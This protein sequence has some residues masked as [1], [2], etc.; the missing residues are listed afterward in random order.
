MFC[1]LLVVW[2]RQP[3]AQRA[4][5]SL[6][7]AISLALACIPPLALIGVWGGL[8]AEGV[9]T[10]LSYQH[11]NATVGLNFVRPLTT[12]LVI[13]V[14]ALPALVF[15]GP[16]V[17]R[18]LP[19]FAVAAAVAS[20]IAHALVPAP[21]L[22]CTGKQIVLCGM[23]DGG[24][25]FVRDNWGGFALGIS[26]AA[27]FLGFLGVICM[28]NAFLISQGAGSAGHAPTFAV[29]FLLF[30]TLG[31]VFVGG[32]IPFYERYVLQVAPMIGF[33]VASSGNFSIERALA[34]SLPL[35]VL[36]QQRL[37]RYI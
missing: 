37:W 16:Q 22:W 36:G 1:V 23:I 8:T 31:Q 26:F 19:R 17:Q 12:A 28:S 33:V 2:I 18:L 7:S 13:G 6:L 3:P 24:Y 29:F 25:W 9:R 15:Q 35:F 21:M 32:N 27:A 20:L 5:L 14:Y 11:F 34:G 10:N 4:F 30:F